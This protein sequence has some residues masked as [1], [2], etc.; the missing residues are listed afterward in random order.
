[1]SIET[2]KF[3]DKKYL[4][5]QAN[6]N[7]VRFIK[8]FVDEICQADY[9]KGDFGFNIGCGKLEWNYPDKAI[10]ID[11]EFDNGKYHA[12]NLPKRGASYI[13]AFHL[14][15]HLPNYVEALKYWYDNL[16]VGGTI[17]LYLPHPEQERWLPQNNPRHLHTFY[18]KDLAKTIEDLGFKNVFYSE[19]DLYWGF[20]VV[21]EK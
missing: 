20:T 5:F 1:M 16:K 15:E 9:N 13:T 12:M 11:I 18:P 2:I 4:A 19:R 10:P 17:F 7:S 3:K 6:G 14:L 8:G 21:G